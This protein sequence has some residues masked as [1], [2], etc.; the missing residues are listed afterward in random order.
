MALPSASWLQHVAAIYTCEILWMETEDFEILE[1]PSLNDLCCT[2]SARCFLAV[3]RALDMEVPSTG[4]IT[5]MSWMVVG[6]KGNYDEQ[7][8]ALG[9]FSRHSQTF[10]TKPFGSLGFSGYIDFPMIAGENPPVMQAS[11]H[12]ACHGQAWYAVATWGSWDLDHRRKM[13]WPQS[14][15]IILYDPL[16]IFGMGGWSTDPKRYVW[17]VFEESRMEIAEALTNTNWQLSRWAKTMIGI[18]T[19]KQGGLLGRILPGFRAFGE[20]TAATG[21]QD[22]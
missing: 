20:T 10:Q 5:Q 3:S 15:F 12:G 7:P 19:N 4:T 1:L 18:F 2:F 16:Y 14:T 8:L 13:G 22:L 9:D 6:T 21:P 11:S 17:L